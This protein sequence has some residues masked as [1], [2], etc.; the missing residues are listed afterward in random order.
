MCVRA[1]A[2]PRARER[3]KGRE[4]LHGNMGNAWM[5]EL[6]LHGNPLGNCEVAS[7]SQ[8]LLSFGL[9]PRFGY[10][11]ILFHSRFNMAQNIKIN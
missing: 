4:C 11:N 8:L 9:G 10:L 1:W 3:R 6:F 7:K 2:R 5:Y